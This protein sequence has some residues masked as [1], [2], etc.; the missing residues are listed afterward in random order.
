MKVTIKKSHSKHI[1]YN[2][3]SKLRRRCQWDRMISIIYN[4]LEDKSEQGKEHDK[5]YCKHWIVTS[6]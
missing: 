1:Q 4:I 2:T 5:H 6:S 3:S